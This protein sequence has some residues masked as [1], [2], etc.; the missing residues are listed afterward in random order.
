MN[1]IAPAAPLAIVALLVGGCARGG[2]V[3]VPWNV[4]GPADLGE[5]SAMALPDPSQRPLDENVELIPPVGTPDNR[6]PDYPS[7]P[8]AARFGT[9]RTV[10][11]IV[12]DAEGRV[13][14]IGDSPVRESTGG[15]YG[16]EFRRAVDEVVRDW[17]F[18]PAQYRVL[19]PGDDR[20][21]DGEP[22]FQY[23]VSST[24]IAV[25]LDVQFSFEIVEGKG[26]VS[27]GPG[28]T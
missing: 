10:V 23:V 9:A 28:R 11:R 14:S 19:R 6:L 18:R 21:G 2:V 3:A 13:T 24:P 22:D 20:D 17:T 7:R 27:L 25:Y 8:L 12:I 26:R 16:D 5:V 4:L 15:V 1:R